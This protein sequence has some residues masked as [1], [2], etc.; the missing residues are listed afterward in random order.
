LEKLQALFA[1]IAHNINKLERLKNK[2]AEETNTGETT[3]VEPTEAQTGETGA[4]EAELQAQKVKDPALAIKNAILQ[5]HGVTPQEKPSESEEG[6]K[7]EGKT[8]QAAENTSAKVE[9]QPKVITADDVKDF[10]QFKTLVGKPYGELAKAYANLQKEYSRTQNELSSLKKIKPLEQ[11]KQTTQQEQSLEQKID[12]L[13]DKTVLPDQLDDP[14]GFKKAF[15]K[16]QTQIVRLQI[17]DSNKPIK[18]QF[19][20][21]RKAEESRQQIERTNALVTSYLEGEEVNQQQLMA[22]FTESIKSVLEDYP[23]YYKDKPELLASD[24]SRFHFAN[25]VQSM[26]NEL[27][28]KEDELKNASVKRQV[29]AKDLKKRIEGAS[30][31]VTVKQALAKPEEKKLS[32]ADEIKK[33]IIERH[34]GGFIIPKNNE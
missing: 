18:D 29:T 8:E 2:M 34:G 28:A 30:E 11:P 24:I 5:R 14:D 3:R 33:K 9:T 6:E 10:P 20:I 31:S 19:D 25:K 26:K 12:E 17:E 15:A 32:P 16:L 13:I 7:P 23:D 1:F 22:D 4:A 27:A 21:Q